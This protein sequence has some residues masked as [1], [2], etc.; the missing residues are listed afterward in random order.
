MTLLRFVIENPDD[1]SCICKI[2]VCFCRSDTIVELCTRSSADTNSELTSSE[3]TLKNVSLEDTEGNLPF[4]KLP[5]FEAHE[6]EE[7]LQL[8]Q[9]A[10]GRRE[11]FPFCVKLNEKKKNL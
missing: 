10:Q 2:I 5:S 9:R 1:M 3:A 4:D 6:S 7:T 8:V 11:L